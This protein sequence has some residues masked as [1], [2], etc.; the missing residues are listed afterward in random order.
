MFFTILK[1]KKKFP[2]KLMVSVSISSVGV[3]DPIFV[4]RPNSVNGEIYREKCIKKGLTPFLHK[5]HSK[6]SNVIFWPDLR[7]IT[8]LKQLQ[9]S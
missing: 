7:L 1:G 6:D 4:E 9:T 8:L 2:V 3:S 5:F